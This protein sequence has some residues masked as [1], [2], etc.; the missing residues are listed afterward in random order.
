[1]VYT[2]RCTHR[3]RLNHRVETYWLLHPE[4]RA[5]G[6]TDRE[7]GREGGRGH[8]RHPWSLVYTAAPTLDNPLAAP[9]VAPPPTTDLRLQVSKLQRQIQHLSTGSGYNNIHSAS[10]FPSSSQSGTHACWIFDSGASYHMTSD[11]SLL[12]TIDTYSIYSCPYYGWFQ[13]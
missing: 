1:M 11:D 3:R 8:G 6:H 10:A 4:L 13:F 5:S 12:T 2:P 7:R 9:L